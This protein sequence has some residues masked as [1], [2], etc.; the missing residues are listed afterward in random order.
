MIY[1][2]SVNE[3]N[4]GNIMIQIET[5]A[6]RFALAFAAKNDVRYYLNGVFIEPIQDGN[7]RLV[8]TNGHIMGVAISRYSDDG[9]ILEAPVIIN[10]D[11][12]IQALKATGRKTTSIGMSV[13]GEVVTLGNIVDKC[14]DATYPDWKRVL[15]KLPTSGEAARFDP[16]YVTEAEKAFAAYVGVTF[17]KKGDSMELHQNGGSAAVIIDARAGDDAIAILMPKG[18]LSVG[19]FEGYPDWLTDLSE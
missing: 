7:L 4:R 3:A 14:I 5:R 8:G 1:F 18:E 9:D 15:P 11:Q 19:P 12:V 10:R 6:L 17:Q 13:D 16:Y 2:T